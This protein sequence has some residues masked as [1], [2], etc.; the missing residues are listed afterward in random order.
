H[1]RM[2]SL[3]LSASPPTERATSS[4]SVHV[5]RSADWHHN[6]DCYGGGAQ[7]RTGPV[8]QEDPLPRYIR[9]LA[10]ARSLV[11]WWAGVQPEMNA[12]SSYHTVIYERQST[13]VTSSAKLAPIGQSLTI[14][15][16]L[17]PSL[18]REAIRAPAGD[19]SPGA[20][21]A[22]DQS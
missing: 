22:V 21:K 12:L 11:V 10:P 8:A 18:A 6:R 16:P 3:K 15:N 2:S 13:E 1:R 14:A 17:R 4:S 7:C 19:A 9:R 20:A 5:M